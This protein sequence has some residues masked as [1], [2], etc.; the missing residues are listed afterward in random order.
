LRS[1]PH[2]VKFL[3]VAQITAL[4]EPAG[5]SW[6]VD[7]ITRH[8]QLRGYTIDDDDSNGKDVVDDD[9]NDYKNDFE[10]ETDKYDI[11]SDQ[12]TPSSDRYLRRVSVVF[13][14]FTL[15][16]SGFHLKH[17]YRN[18]VIWRIATFR[19]KGKVEKVKVARVKAE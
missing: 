15:F 12:N 1:S 7:V 10:G 18:L 3:F 16:I 11:F 8:R 2:N 17:I 9:S 14:I 19:A 4:N 13:F 5:T 6:P